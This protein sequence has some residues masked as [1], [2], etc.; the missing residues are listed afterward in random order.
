MYNKSDQ[1]L[2]SYY[3]SCDFALPSNMCINKLIINPPSVKFD[4]KV[5]DMYTTG[6]NNMF[7]FVTDYTQGKSK[8]QICKYDLTTTLN[9]I[10]INSCTPQDIGNIIIKQS[11]CYYYQGKELYFN[12]GD[13][14]DFIKLTFEDVIKETLYIKDSNVIVAK[15]NNNKTCFKDMNDNQ[16][17]CVTD[18]NQDLP[19][20]ERNTVEIISSLNTEHVL[21]KEETDTLEFVELKIDLGVLS[22][23][24]NRNNFFIKELNNKEINEFTS[25]NISSSDY[26][27]EG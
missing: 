16:I 15:L 18:F 21:I 13:A 7:V 26:F 3:H 9:E 17:S 20:I 25:T 19:L 14:K 8:I 27:K 6:Y 5:I 23:N 1:T 22:I 4:F 10:T 2:A 11:L 24:E 12:R